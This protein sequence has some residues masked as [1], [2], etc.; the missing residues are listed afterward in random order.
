MHYYQFHIGDY[1]SHTSHLSDTEDLAYRRMLDW[2][3][4]HESPLPLDPDAIARLIRMRSHSECIAVV[5]QEFWVRT[6]DGWINAR[7]DAEMAKAAE[8]SD[9]AKASAKRRWEKTPQELEKTP[10][11][12]DLSP[13]VPKHANALRS[14]SEGNATQ[15]PIPKNQYPNKN[16]PPGVP[17][18]LW[19]D[20]LQLRKAKRAPLSKTAIDG[21]QREAQKAGWNLEDALRECVSRGWQSFKAEWVQNKQ[22]GLEAR[23]RAVGEAW[24]RKREVLDA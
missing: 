7:A 22:E 4:L 11:T 19:S 17:E 9:K 10:S 5:L 24:L 21:I 15:Y 14:Q 8:K 12:S 6:S 23:N 2:T 1:Q 20:F 3:Y 18:D 13:P 16:K